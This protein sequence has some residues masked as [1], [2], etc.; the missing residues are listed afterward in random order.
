MGPD[1]LSPLRSLFSDISIFFARQ[2]EI[3]EV[4]SYPLVI[5]DVLIVATLF[6]WI[7]LLL[8]G[9]RGMRILFGLMV[10]GIALF[11]SHLLNLIALSWVLRSFLAVAVIAI[12]IIFQPEL[13]RA[14]EKLGR[15]SVW[16]FFKGGKE[17]SKNVLEIAEASRILA[18]NKIGALIVIK[19][20]T[21]LNEY[22]ETGT[23]I[24]AKLSARLLLNLFFPHSP[25]H[26][27]AV[28][29]DDGKIIAA[30]CTLPL[31]ETDESFKYGTRH[32]AALGI[33]AETDALVIVISEEKG[34][35]SLCV[36]GK[37][38]PNISPSALETHLI[39][40]LKLNKR[41]S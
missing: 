24:E 6:Y 23:R 17:L 12:P 21:G 11:L 29:I 2:I 28:I 1:I 18:K 7:Y 32:K 22:I 9:T 35:I 38:I 14:L 41:T 27:G 26:D 3:F 33:S 25:L 20:K 4:T 37:L 19:R 16:V 13:R 15:T 8:K 36:D 10:L 5:L 31:L 40:L 30:G 34:A 39:K